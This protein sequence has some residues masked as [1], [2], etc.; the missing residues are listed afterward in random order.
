MMLRKTYV[1][2]SELVEIFNAKGIA[3]ARK[4]WD[5]GEIG[6]IVSKTFRTAAEAEAYES[7]LAD[8]SGWEAYDST[9]L[10]GK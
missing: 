8:G 2:G 3:A 9:F 6:N 4:A 5:E 7:G 1:F 10:R